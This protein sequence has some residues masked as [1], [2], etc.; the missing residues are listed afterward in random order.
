MNNSIQPKIKNTE[1]ALIML[2]LFFVFSSVVFTA[3]TERKFN[4]SSSAKLSFSTDTLSFDTVFTTFGSL[5]QHF[6]IYNPHQDFLNISR[7]KLAKGDD[8]YFR[9]NVNGVKQSELTNIE[10]APNDS[11]YVFV[12]VTVNPQDAN[13]PVLVRD[14]VVFDTNNNLQDVKLIAYGQ[15]VHLINGEIIS[16]STWVADKPYL[17][18]NSMLIDSLET[19]TIEPGVTV[20]FSDN[21]NLLVK[22]T[23]NAKGT[24]QDSITF[25]SDRTDY[26]YNDVPGLWS[27]I[28][29]LAGS[30]DNVF[31]Y[32]TIK[33]AIVGIRAD[34]TINTGKPTVTLHNSR[35]EHHTA[36]G[37]F[38]QGSHVFASNTIFGDCGL[39]SISL[40]VGGK[41][42]FHHCTVAN[43]WGY[44]NRTTPSVVIRNYYYDANNS[45][46]LRPIE[47]AH[48]YN[49]IIYGNKDNEIVLDSTDR[50][51]Y[52]YSF[53]NCLLRLDPKIDYSEA[54]EY[55]TC[56]INENPNFTDLGK[57]DY[58]LKKES[59]AIDAG[60]LLYVKAFPSLLTEDPYLN[61]RTIDA[62][63]DLGTFEYKEEE[64]STEKQ[65]TMLH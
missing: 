60:S 2:V 9:L 37:L 54:P 45:I 50:T 28:W 16:T 3:C 40:Q 48:F 30:V 62:A 55:S 43:Y 29:L 1:K 12:E 21:S 56:I 47:A 58:S 36:V 51:E 46:S 59:P 25:T 22:G 19:L 17:V 63:P 52:N 27:G 44:T 41:Y 57:Y 31:E 32:T 18:R 11:L 20:H 24:K 23:I 33:N 7:L 5:T 26:T 49:C 14:S 34:S 65:N 13:N 35:I 64:E 39:Y 38:A 6:K 4:N 15:D 10:I 42:N 8:S 61:N 53:N